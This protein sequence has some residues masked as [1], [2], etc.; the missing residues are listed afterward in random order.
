MGVPSILANII[1]P[2]GV[3]IH[4]DGSVIGGIYKIMFLFAIFGRE[5]STINSLSIDERIF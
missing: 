3:N 2:V 1:M 4:K 5:M